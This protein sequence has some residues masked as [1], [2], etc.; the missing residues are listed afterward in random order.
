MKNIRG[1]L[2][3]GL[4]GLALV[5]GCAGKAQQG[6]ADNGR[7]AIAVTENGFEPKTV[8]VPAGWRWAAR[9]ATAAAASCTPAAAPPVPRSPR[10]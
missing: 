1:L 2:G 7:I 5:A 9:A 4:M 3:G 10:R 8:T 6:A